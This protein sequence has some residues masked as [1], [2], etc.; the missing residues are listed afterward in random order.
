MWGAGPAFGELRSLRAAGS[1]VSTPARAF[2]PAVPGE[3]WSPQ[4][5]AGS[6]SLSEEVTPDH[7][8][9]RTEQSRGVSFSAPINHKTDT[10]AK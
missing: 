8:S 2:G 6:A 1:P 7:F 4:T 3:Q 10:P 9:E 5:P